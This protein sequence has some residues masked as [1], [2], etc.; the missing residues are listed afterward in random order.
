MSTVGGAPLAPHFLNYAKLPC[1][2]G[3]HL[4]DFGVIALPDFLNELIVGFRAVRGG[5]F[6]HLLEIK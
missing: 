6:D 3:L 1:A 5:L 2:Q 4:V